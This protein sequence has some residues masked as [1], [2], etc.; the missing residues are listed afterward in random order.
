MVINFCKFL[1]ARVRAGLPMTYNKVIM[2]AFGAIVYVRLGIA[3]WDDDTWV[4]LP[5]AGLTS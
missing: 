5:G 2:S 3:H 1:Q 4:H